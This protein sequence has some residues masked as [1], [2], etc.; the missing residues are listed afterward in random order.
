MGSEMCIR[1]SSLHSPKIGPLWFAS[2]VLV[3]SEQGTGFGPQEVRKQINL[4]AMAEPFAGQVAEISVY[5]CHPLN[6]LPCLRVEYPPCQTCLW[7]WMMMYAK[8]ENMGYIWNKSVPMKEYCCM[9]MRP[10]SPFFLCH[11]DKCNQ[12]PLGPRDQ[13]SR[14]AS[15]T[16]H[17]GPKKKLLRNRLVHR[18]IGRSCLMEWHRTLK[19]VKWW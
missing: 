10:I 17:P 8:L 5:R 7:R 14:V 19:V 12:R 15:A 2:S 3:E 16:R 4:S 18:K 6:T 13:N 9:P 1:D 11:H